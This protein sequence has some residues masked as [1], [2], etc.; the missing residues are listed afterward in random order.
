MI[1]TLEYSVENSVTSMFISPLKFSPNNVAGRVVNHTNAI[2]PA[3]KVIRIILRVV[4]NSTIIV[5]H[6]KLADKTNK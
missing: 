1:T 3:I 6:R 2:T 5:P 4:S